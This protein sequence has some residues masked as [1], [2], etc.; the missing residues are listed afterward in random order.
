MLNEDQV[1]GAVRSV[2]SAVGGFAIGRGWINSEQLTLITGVAAS[3]VPLLWSIAVHTDKAKIA[4][5]QAVPAA[6]VLV[7]DPALASAGVKVASPSG[8]ATVPVPVPKPA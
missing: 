5:A 3:L 1:M 2:I 4:A 6:Q 7:S 8:P